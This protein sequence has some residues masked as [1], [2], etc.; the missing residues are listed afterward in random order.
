MAPLGAFRPDLAELFRALFDGAPALPPAEREEWVPRVDVEGTE[1]GLLVTVD[2]PGIDPREVEVSVDD[3]VLVIRGE[4]KVE[5]KEDKEEKEG[6][7]HLR[8]R[9]IGKFY[10]AMKLP[11]EIDPEKI[12]AISNHGVLTLTLPYKPEVKPRKIDV[13]LEG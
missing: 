7:L 12:S 13:H 6:T 11:R 8:E 1:K 4:K 3:G 2:L 5:K 10:R 9:T